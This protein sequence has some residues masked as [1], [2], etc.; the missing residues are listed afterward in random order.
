MREYLEMRVTD[1]GLGPS[2]AF[3]EYRCR[4]P[5][6]GEVTGA[7]RAHPYRAI[8]DLVKHLSSRHAAEG[9]ADTECVGP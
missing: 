6:C 8:D 4:C 9:S 3:W 2:G 7:A 1:L 5:E